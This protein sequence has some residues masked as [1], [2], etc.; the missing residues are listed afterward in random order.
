MTQVVIL[1]AGM[2]GSAF[3]LP[4]CEAGQ[5]VHLVG[6]HLDREW[7]EGIRTDG[8]HPRLKAKLPELVTPFTHDQLEEALGDETD[9][10][11]LGV[12]SPGVKWAIQQL[13]PL[14]KKLHKPIPILMLTKGLLADGQRLH[15]LPDVVRDGL[16]DY[17]LENVT[18]GAV[19]GPCLAT[20]LAVRR[21]CCVMITFRDQEKIDWV[22]SLVAAPY[23]HTLPSTD[24][25]GVEVCAALKNFYALGIPY[26]RGAAEKQEKPSNNALMFS[27]ESGLFTQALIEMKY[28]VKFLGGTDATVDGWAGSGDMYGTCQVGR[29]GR[30]GKFLGYG[31][32]YKETKAKYMP[33]DTI[34]GVDVALMIGSTI[35]HL[36]DQQRLDSASL[37]FTLSIIRAICHD[38]P[39]SIPWDQM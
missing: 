16:T 10:I 18:V 20:E 37:P 6:T 12:S 9:L 8:I 2:M 39:M 14:L 33:D 19:G 24:T 17:G 7:I 5:K 38:Q 13:G 1:G 23:Y 3:S 11:V 28:L 29:N 31:L 21:D 22:R 25:V 35:E 15:I 34:E 32:P 26:P 27:L 36:V 30:M 4:L